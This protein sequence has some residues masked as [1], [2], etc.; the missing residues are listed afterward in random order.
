ML[1]LKGWREW[2]EYWARYLRN[3]R[4]AEMYGIKPLEKKAISLVISW[5]DSFRSELDKLQE[6]EEKKEF[7]E[8]MDYHIG[9]FLGAVRSITH[10]TSMRIP[11]W[12]KDQ[13]IKEVFLGG[14]LTE[15]WL[16]HLKFS[17]KTLISEPY[18]IGRV[19]VEHLIDFCNRYDLDFIIDGWSLHFPGRCV[20]IR[21][22]PKKEWG[23]YKK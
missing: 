14:T 5:G 3:P 10:R 22:L 12:I 1:S 2:R 11:K 17:G 20:R 15:Y 16:D 6:K 7:C 13:D 23:W 9:L 19:S 4:L 8:H 21:I 18:G